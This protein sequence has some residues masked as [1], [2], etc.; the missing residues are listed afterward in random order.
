MKKF[1]LMAALAFAFASSAASANS[2]D[3]QNVT[4]STTNL[5][6]GELQL[7]I[8]NAL[9]ANGD[10]TGIK[11]LQSFAL[12]NVGSFTNANI[13]GFTYEA[14]GLNN[15]GCNGHGA[16]WAC[17]L[18]TPGPLALSSNNMVFDIF[19]TGG[20]P[21]FSLPSLKVDFFTNLSQSNA[22]GNL[23]SQS[24]GVS[25]TP[26]P[27]SW[28]MMLIGLAAAVG[29]MTFRRKDKTSLAAA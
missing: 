23:L 1:T 18:S 14:G 16:G 29:V 5:G 4:F 19:F 8:S 20:T 7:T 11:Y 24:I 25:Q 17:F 10:W 2:L 22:T 6:G 15:G 9:N 13:A 27:A 3:F 12:N 28:T 26:L 21:D